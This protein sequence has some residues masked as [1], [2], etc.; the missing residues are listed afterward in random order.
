MIPVRL[1]RAWIVQGL[2]DAARADLSSRLFPRGPEAHAPRPDPRRW[3]ALPSC[4]REAVE[5]TDVC[6]EHREGVS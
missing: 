6:E 1:R 4:G 2:S 3:C 5:G